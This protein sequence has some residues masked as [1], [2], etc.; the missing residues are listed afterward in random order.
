MN[1]LIK[2]AKIIDPS[3]S[4]NNKIK[5]ILILDGKIEKIASRISSNLYSSKYN[6]KV[7]KSKNLN[8]SP[9][10]FDLH[11]N[12][13][14]P[15]YEHRENLKT[16]SQA[17]IKG[18]FT[19]V[20]LMPNT[21]PKI[22]NK[23][24]LEYILNKN[25]D[26]ILDI[27]PAAN[28]TKNQEGNEI[29][30]MHDLS[31]AGCLAFT[32]DKHS[33]KNNNVLKIAL[34]YSKDCNSLIM[35]F[36]YD[37][38]ISKDGCMNEGIISTN[39]GLKGIPTL[40]EEIMLDRDINL[41]KY[42]NGKLHISYLSAKNSI[43]KI[44]KAKKEGLHVSCDVALH[45]LILTDSQV[46]NFD[47]RYKV[48][49]PLR[50][51]NDNNSLINGLKN[52][53]IDIITCDHTPFEEERKKIEF[54]NAAYGIIGLE[55]GFGLLCKH[56]VPK[57]GINKLI[58]KISINP[59]KLLGIKIPSIENKNTANITL[60]DTD[61]EW[62]FSKDD[63]KSQSSNSPFLGEKLIGKPIAIYNNGK[64]KEC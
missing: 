18:G 15:G 16:G 44:K 27:F 43:S 14:D 17:A 64:F 54:S 58:E 49:P 25:N 28:L 8:V 24:T 26:N 31:R 60:F 29:V 50:T 10:W 20:M 51:Q 62:I 45:N 23:S 5:D 21:S 7:I 53:T 35:N 4:F 42:T 38:Q 39:L 37:N 34:L 56:I 52:D 36:P 48:L 32:D 63:V 13:C 22:D 3:S 47:T 12:F 57:I 61:N 30:E 19:G 2:S 46:N 9:G 6:V 59:R 1:I 55:S 33:I 41:C 40:S 11:V